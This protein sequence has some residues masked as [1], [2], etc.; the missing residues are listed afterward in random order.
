VI[1]TR[2]RTIFVWRG[3]ILDAEIAM[4]MEIEREEKRVNL[5]SGLD[6]TVAKSICRRA[7]TFR[8][9][10]ECGTH[11]IQTGTPLRQ[12]RPNQKRGASPN[13]THRAT[14]PSRLHPPSS[15][16]NPRSGPSSKS[17]RRVN[18]RLQGPRGDADEA[19]SP[20]WKKRRPVWCGSA[21]P[22]HAGAPRGAGDADGGVG[23]I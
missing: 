9:A 3:L 1:G 4:K 15:V 10:K 20:V 2:V 11:L 14:S 12:F 19:P 8:D 18:E 5:T 6:E 17:K 16:P 13:R 23:A 21:R 7:F 22:Q